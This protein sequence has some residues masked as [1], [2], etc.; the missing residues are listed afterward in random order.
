LPRVRTVIL[1]LLFSGAL[2]LPLA[3][4]APEAAPAAPP[5]APPDLVRPERLNEVVVEYPTDLAQ[6]ADAPRGTILVRFTLGVDGQPKDLFIEAGLDPQLDAIALAAVAKLRYRPALFGGQPVEVIDR[7]AISFEP[8][9]P[10]EPPTPPPVPPPTEDDTNVPSTSAAPPSLE[11][12]GPVRIEGR[13]LVA[14]Q[15][16]PIAGATIVVVPA[17]DD[18]RPG[19]VR[20]T[21]YR[22]TAGPAWEANT[23]TR[24]D[25]S[26]TIRG[27]PD[28][29]VQVVVI[30]PGFERLE[31]IEALAGGQ[32]V[33][34]KYYPQRLPTNPYRTVVRTEVEREEVARRTIT[35]EEI[36]AIPGTQGDALKALQNFPGVA[37]SPFG[38][39][40]LVIRGTGPNDSAT[41]LGGHRIPQ[42]FHFGALT[43][44]FNSDILE[45]IDF[46]PGNFDTRYGD[47]IGGIIDVTPRAGRRDGFHG[48]IDADVFDAGVLFEG[49]VGKGSFALSGRRSYLDALLPVF[50]PDDAG[51]NPTIAPRYYDYQALFDYPVGG[52]TLS[53]RAFGS[54]DKTVLVFASPNDVDTNERDQFETATYFHRADLAYT[55]QKGPWSF[56]IIPSYRRDFFTI[57]FGELFR[58]GVTSDNAN[59][60][61]EVSRRLSRRTELAVGTETQ[62][63][64][65][66]I[67]VSAPP[68][69][70]PGDQGGT[71]QRLATNLRFFAA[72]PA[73]YT[74]VAVGI[75]DK[76]T[77]Y[78]GARVTLYTFPRPVPTF[79]PRV[80][81]AWALGD[82]S[83]LKG[84]TGLHTQDGEG[85]ELTDVYGNPRLGPEYS[86]Q[87]SLGFQHQFDYG[88]RLDA[89]AFYNHVWN[90]ITQS[91]ETILRDDG[92]FGPE[93]Y[94]N[95][96][97]RRI[98]GLEVFLRKELTSNVFAWL[99]YTLSRSEA[100]STEHGWQRFDFDQPHIL[101]LV[102]VYKLPRNW[103]IGLRFRL[104]SGNPSTPVVTGKY[105]ASSGAYI[106]INGARNSDRLPVFHQLDIRVDKAWIYRRVSWRL[107]LDIQNVYN[108]QNVE[109][110]NPAYDFSTRQPIAGLPLIPSIGG[111]L[112]F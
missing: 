21:D 36:N 72:T 79:E 103:Q 32:V 112:E 70:G 85:A 61:A 48:S 23:S 88:I 14:G 27:I 71:A 49:P 22:E 17:P 102:G 63:G 93:N 25:G 1:A 66:D 7:I 19:H 68:L 6:R 60:R 10:P 58:I 4:A 56:L 9:P 65:F 13:I 46:I 3:L 43:S 97:T 38:A 52:G 62:T 108:A 26:F 50:V 86:F 18:A 73:L 110:W 31:F 5:T 111:K 41:Y 77:L 37:R 107:Y 99:A 29:K 8:P 2:E 89:T 109:F 95:T 105:D 28:G 54:D 12:S 92:K 30:A 76:F 55:K 67:E 74:T 34:V 39:G 96:E 84:G 81:F 24:E 40:A 45:K 75:T 16:T 47:A 35:V 94:A 53:I 33:T 78:P 101:T 51:V 57:G 83:T 42:L 44:V 100:R 15:R 106:P 91:F 98:Y 80:R 11:A 64:W 82:R 59:L 104:V 90:S 69:P 20:K 87:N